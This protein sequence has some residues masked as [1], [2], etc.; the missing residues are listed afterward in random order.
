MILML[1]TSTPPF[2]RSQSRPSLELYSVSPSRSHILEATILLLVVW[3]RCALPV[4]R[5][6][7]STN[8]WTAGMDKSV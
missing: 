1:S 4:L 3:N 5:A 8:C 7:M 2:T 6:L